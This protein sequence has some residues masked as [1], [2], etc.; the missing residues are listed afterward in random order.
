MKISSTDLIFILAILTIGFIG[1]IMVG[2]SLG[3]P[4]CEVVI[5]PPQDLYYE[6]EETQRQY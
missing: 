1:G 5:T 3:Y 4:E 2:M 6:S